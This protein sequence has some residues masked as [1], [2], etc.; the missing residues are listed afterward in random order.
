MLKHTH[1]HMHR[2]I[3]VYANTAILNPEYIFSK[4]RTKQDKK[5][6]KLNY[7]LYF[8]CLLV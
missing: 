7:N 5:S 2:Y 1:M 8:I 4:N 6:Y 3:H